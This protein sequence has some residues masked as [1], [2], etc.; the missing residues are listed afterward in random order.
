MCRGFHILPNNKIAS[1][2]AMSMRPIP[3]FPRMNSTTETKNS[4]SKGIRVT[5]VI[6]VINSSLQLRQ[7]FNRRVSL[8]PTTSQVL[9][10]LDQSYKLILLSLSESQFSIK[11]IRFVGKHFEVTSSSASI[12]GLRKLRRVLRRERQLLLVFPELSVLVIPNQHVR[13]F[14][15]GL[16]DRTVECEV[17]KLLHERSYWESCQCERSHLRSWLSDQ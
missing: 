15:K 4:E 1:A 10:D 14:A 11:I 8:L 5:P 3:A 9:I 13:N 17:E 16:L 12:P 7:R 6:V 2:A